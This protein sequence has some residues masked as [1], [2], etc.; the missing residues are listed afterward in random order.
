MNSKTIKKY[1]DIAALN[2]ETYLLMNSIGWDW[3]S[4]EKSLIHNNKILL[5]LEVVDETR[6]TN[7]WVGF[8]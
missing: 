7:E 2:K 1:Q 5:S 6:E 4:W 3:G 8:V